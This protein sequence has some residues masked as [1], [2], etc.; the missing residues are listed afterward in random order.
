LLWSLGK[1]SN[2]LFDLHQEV[3]GGTAL[4]GPAALAPNAVFP[5]RSAMAPCERAGYKG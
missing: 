4:I 5:T 2:V 1:D 3:V